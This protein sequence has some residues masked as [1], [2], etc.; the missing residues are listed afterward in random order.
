L[1]ALGGVYY[2][3]W[4]PVRY[5]EHMPQTSHYSAESKIA[6]DQL[7]AAYFCF[8][9]VEGLVLRVAD[10]IAVWRATVFAL[11]VCDAGHIYAAWVEMGTPGFFCPWLWRLNDA[12]TMVMTLAPFVLR[13]AFLCEV[14]FQQRT[15]RRRRV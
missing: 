8:A 12:A 3:H 5:F 15:M 2:L 14:G 10:D 9:I 7:A 4:D 1:T 13:V 11:L 6:Y